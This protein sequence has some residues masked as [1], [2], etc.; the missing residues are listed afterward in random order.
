MKKIFIPIIFATLMASCEAP[1]DKRSLYMSSLN[2]QSGSTT[3]SSTGGTTTGDTGGGRDTGSTTDVTGSTIP[4][5]AKHCTWSTD[6]ST[7][8]SDSSNTHIGPNNVCRSSATDTNVYIQ[9]KNP[10]TDAQ[11]CIFPTYESNGKSFYIGNPRCFVASEAGKLYKISL[12]KDRDSGKYSGLT[13]NSV[14][15]VK[16]KAYFYGTPFYQWVLAPD[17]YMYCSK[18]LELYNNS[19]YCQAFKS[20]GEYLYKRF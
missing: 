6:N 2:N 16:D 9:I 8:Y 19:S 11:I 7:N 12:F 14:M 18:F 1:R 3:G 13:M 10:Q 5:D 15:I 17:A 20:K 4:D